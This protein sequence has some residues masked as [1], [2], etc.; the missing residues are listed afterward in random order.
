MNKFVV[1]KRI[2]IRLDQKTLQGCI[3]YSISVYIV[4]CCSSQDK[5][6]ARVIFNHIIVYSIVGAIIRD[7]NAC[8]SIRLMGLVNNLV[9][10]DC[11]VGCA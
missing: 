3:F 10:S 7:A 11:R 4:T 8:V 6:P 9:P 1:G 5:D 2:A